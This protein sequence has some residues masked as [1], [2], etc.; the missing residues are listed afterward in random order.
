VCA[1]IADLAFSL[2]F[3]SADDTITQYLKT[4]KILRVARILKLVKNVQGIQRLIQTIT[5][6]FPAL[7]NATSLLFLAYF[8][9]SVLASN[10]FGNISYLVYAPDG[11]YFISN[12]GLSSRIYRTIRS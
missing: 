7:M 8:I 1:S 2:I 12:L 3:T 10:L 11:S 6:S 9:F 5:F 4:L